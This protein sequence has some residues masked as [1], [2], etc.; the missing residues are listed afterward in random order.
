MSMFSRLIV[1]VALIAGLAILPGV[2]QARGT[3]G[4][5]SAH[6]GCITAEGLPMEDG[7][8]FTID[9]VTFSCNNG[10]VCRLGTTKAESYCYDA[11]LPKRVLPGGDGPTKPGSRHTVNKRLPISKRI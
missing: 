2:A 3:G 8:S 1:A 4:P 7:E 6:R 9:G 5:T 11:P 10:N